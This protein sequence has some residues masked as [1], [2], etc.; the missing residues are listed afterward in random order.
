VLLNQYLTTPVANEILEKHK[1]TVNELSRANLISW[2]EARR[3]EKLRELL[4]RAR[5][6]PKTI[7]IKAAFCIL[8]VRNKV[9]HKGKVL[10]LKKQL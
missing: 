7:L 6:D 2:R 5:S 1:E 3:N 9:F 8:E 10:E 4:A